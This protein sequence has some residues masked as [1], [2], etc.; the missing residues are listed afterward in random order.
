MKYET[1]TVKKS[2]ELM[3]VTLNRP[4]ILNALNKQSMLDLKNLLSELRAD[5][6]TRFVIF[7]GAGRAF[8]AGVEFTNKA[9]AE[10]YST[11]DLA[12]ERLWQLFGH[13]FMSSMENLEQITVAAINGPAIGGGLCIAMNCDFRIASE[14]AILGIPEAALGI[15]YTWGATPRL[16]ALIGPAKAKEMIMTCDPIDAS[17]ALR[18]G[19]VNKVVPH[20]KLMDACREL[21]GK[22]S[23][24]G[25]LAI[26]ICKKQVNAASISRMADLYP[27]E[28][29]LVEM[30]INSGQAAEG[31]SAFIEKRRPKYTTTGKDFSI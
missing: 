25:P 29:E 16:T 26:R 19:F 27:L 3:T 12:N 17:E 28:P 20:E 31:A 18:I 13:D 10:R 30:V 14:K 22:I 5:T 23:T 21:V 8:S 4:E 6:K 24:K 2:G 15:F 11:P 1:L 9:M 7:T